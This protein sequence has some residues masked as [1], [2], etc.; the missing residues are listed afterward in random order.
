MFNRAKNVTNFA[1]FS[2]RTIIM[3]DVQPS[4]SSPN[5]FV[6]KSK[7]QEK[8]IFQTD[9]KRNVSVGIGQRYRRVH[10]LR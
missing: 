8:L 2:V 1:R 6:L 7:F 4:I 3:Q 9:R 5:T 10:Y